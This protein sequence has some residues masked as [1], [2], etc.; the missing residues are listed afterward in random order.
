MF[1]RHA[2]GALLSAYVQ[3]QLTLVDRLRFE[4]HLGLCRDC[5]VHLRHLRSMADEPGGESPAPLPGAVRDEILTRF[6]D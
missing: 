5:R 3:R 2:S 1:R 4:L 6:K